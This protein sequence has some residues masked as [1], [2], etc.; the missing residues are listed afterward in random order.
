MMNAFSASNSLFHNTTGGSSSTG[1]SP[2]QQHPA[3]QFSTAITHQQKSLTPP[4]ISM[5]SSPIN[6]EQLLQA[7]QNM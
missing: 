2:T 1:S 5:A 4:P 6:L 7:T 3:Q